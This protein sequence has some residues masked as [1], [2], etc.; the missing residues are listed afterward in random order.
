MPKRCAAWIE[1]P[2]MFLPTSSHCALSSSLFVAG[3]QMLLLACLLAKWPLLLLHQHCVE[4]L[5]LYLLVP[6]P[7]F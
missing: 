4:R 2:K 6:F 5:C 3:P 1:F 7:E